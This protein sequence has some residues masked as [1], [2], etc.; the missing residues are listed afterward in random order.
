MGV[1][2]RRKVCPLAR[3]ERCG[4]DKNSYRNVKTCRHCFKLLVTNQSRIMHN[5]VLFLKTFFNFEIINL[6]FRSC[7]WM[8]IGSGS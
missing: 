7:I 6:T 4:L 5:H 2:E 1:S 3:H 8:K